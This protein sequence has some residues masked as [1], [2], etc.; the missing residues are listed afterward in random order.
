[1]WYNG[2]ASAVDIT[3]FGPPQ[4]IAGDTLSTF[5]RRRGLALL[6]Y[7]AVSPGPQ[8]RDSLLA[9][10]Y[11]EFSAGDARN[12]LRRD[13][14]LLRNALPDGAL[15]ADRTTLTLI[16]EHPD[17]TIDVV[18]FARHLEM[19]NRHDHP[20]DTLCDDCRRQLRQAAELYAGD[21]LS[22]FGLPDSVEFDD[23]SLWQRERLRADLES[24][25][26]RLV[27]WEEEVGEPERAILHSLRL[28][29]LAP[30]DDSV[31]RCLMRLYADTGQTAAAL[32]QYEQLEHRLQRDYGIKPETAT[33]SLAHAILSP[34]GSTNN[35]SDHRAE[36]PAEVSRERLQTASALPSETLPLIGRKRELEQL[37]AL[38]EQRESRLL[39]IRGAGGA[40][41]TRLAQALAWRQ[42]VAFN[43][44][45][46]WIDLDA[47]ESTSEVVAAVARALG[48][49]LRDVEDPWGRVLQRV[50]E[51]KRLLVFDNFEHLLEAGDLLDQLLAAGSELRIVT[52]T[53]RPLGRRSETVFPLAGLD[54]DSEAVALFL[55]RA[56]QTNT[57]FDPDEKIWLRS[58]RWLKALEACPWPWSWPPPG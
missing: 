19:A 21:F 22:G 47:L 48:L 24:I 49:S 28:T 50:G 43:G 51:G 57:A 39:T 15:D 46:S 9:L 27:A 33:I 55:Q 30:A 2:Q 20:P 11:P 26:R 41:K 56:R 18:E 5:R 44:A 58:P 8:P 52:T 53:R 17:L 37:A 23:W 13:L 12:N 42:H 3:L 29:E 7:L 1:M 45:V 36:S 31:V 4:I 34:S 32:R 6:A 14:S 25:L 40:G 35:V 10:I 54:T 16:R 38:L